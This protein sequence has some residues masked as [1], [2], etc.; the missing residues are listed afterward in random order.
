MWTGT[1]TPRHSIGAGRPADHALAFSDSSNTFQVPEGSDDEASELE[2]SQDGGADDTMLELDSRTAF[3]MRTRAP[4]LIDLTA[5]RAGGR[6]LHEV[7]DLSSPCPSPIH[8]IDD[9]EEVEEEEP[10]NLSDQLDELDG[11][12]G[13]DDIGTS[14]VG[15]MTHTEIADTIVAHPVSGATH[16]IYDPRLTDY[17]EDMDDLDGDLD[18]LSAEDDDG[19]DADPDKYGSHVG[20]DFYL[21]D[22]SQSGCSEEHSDDDLDSDDDSGSDSDMG[23]AE[24]MESEADYM[25]NDHSIEIDPYDGKIPSY[26]AQRSLPNR[27]AISL[28]DA[29]D[30]WGDLPPSAQDFDY[31]E[32]EPLVASL[33]APV[34]APAPPP[35][36][37]AKPINHMEA[38]KPS[39][40]RCAPSCSI[41]QLLNREKPLPTV[42][43]SSNTGFRAPAEGG[44]LM[45]PQPSA[46][47]TTTAAAAQVLGAKTGKTDFFMA[48]EQNKMTLGAQKIG[49]H[50]PTLSVHALCNSE[51]AVDEPGNYNFGPAAVATPVAPS[52]M[53]RLYNPDRASVVF[54]R[55][56]VAA[57]SVRSAAESVKPAAESLKPTAESLKPATAPAMSS[58]GLSNAAACDWRAH[59]GIHDIVDTCVQE[60]R[61]KL[62]KRKAEDISTTTEEQENWVA[63]A[64]S[65]APLIVDEQSP[66]PVEELPVVL[67]KGGA[68]APA[69]VSCEPESPRKKRRMLRVAERLGYAALGGVT[70]GA[71]IMGT[72]IY[73][74][75]TFS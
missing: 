70:A 26:P 74:A 31:P 15:H 63:K 64:P 52:A 24:D 22:E 18:E 72:L 35:T 58:L 27:C 69:V 60:T 12:D 54:P 55:R 1:T 11:I 17:E 47:T 73:T 61:E 59:V 40:P 56:D 2:D 34:P 28:V 67:E 66:E 57:E 8:I 43:P 29:P 49:N 65:P 36:L 25:P 4:P 37:P 9:D 23:S 14:T 6:Q 68:D 21:D 5:P 45:S 19:S 39:A 50:W 51:E 48:R 41:E 53:P 33:S 13:P 32:V 44:G 10:T 62:A 16:H 42:P 7:I 71:M 46:S 75:P 3:G 38:P 20:H 30:P